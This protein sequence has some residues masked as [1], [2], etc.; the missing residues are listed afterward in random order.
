MEDE[1]LQSP[2]LVIRTNV[3]PKEGWWYYLKHE[4]DENGVNRVSIYAQR[5]RRSKP[6]NHVH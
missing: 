4:H 6:S 5:R 2:R 3:V 1:L